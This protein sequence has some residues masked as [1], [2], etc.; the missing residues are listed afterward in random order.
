MR[1]Q[2]ATINSIA[3]T[4]TVVLMAVT[5]PGYGAG[6]QISEQTVTGLG[7]AFAG[8]G[9][10]GDDLSD[11]F[12]NPAS[13]ALHDERQFQAGLSV[14]SIDSKFQN[15]GSTQTLLGSAGPITIPSSGIDDNGGENA[16]VPNI[17]YVFPARGAV[18]YGF[19]ITAPFG[20]KTQYDSNWVG[21][22]HALT[23]E[24]K[25]IDI[26]PAVSFA[27]NDKVS[28]G[29]G[30]SVQ[31]VD[32]TLSQA[33]FLGLGVPDGRAE[34]TGDNT[35]FGFNLGIMART[36]NDARF[37]VSFRSKIKQDVEGNLDISGTPADGRFGAKT[38]VDLPETIYL[39][40]VA[41]L[42]PNWSILGGARWTKW[43]RFDE[44]R[45]SFDNGA[46]DS[47]TDESW[48]DSLTL[49]IGFS[50]E[51]DNSP[52]TWRFG[53]AHDESPV[54]NA[55][56]RTPRVPDSDRDWFTVGA[57][58]RSSDNVSI[59]F[60]FAHLEADDAKL[61]STVNLVSTAPGLFTDTL[62]GEYASNSVD[63]LGIQIQVDFPA[64]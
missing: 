19:S 29:G 25:T 44:L 36:D 3:V 55:Q 61:T 31:F 39:H 17:Y 62:V 50:Y 46:P 51:R 26:N 64:N 27:V 32:A 8:S 2:I 63:I 58:Y 35:G 12:Y 38:T 20:L 37:G 24:L 34:I 16:V 28:I 40:G 23:S 13:M 14:L 6:F 11:M 1:T 10:A 54:P 52:W 22:Y 41:P 9:V 49:S 59:D 21:R 60:G 33:V 4:A 15:Q 7:R 43:S 47:V 42:S 18:R 5:T 57:S 53:F 48:D 45:V 56:R 30:I